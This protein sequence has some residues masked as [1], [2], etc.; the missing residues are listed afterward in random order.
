MHM[1]YPIC[2]Q[3]DVLINHSGHACLA[4]FGTSVLAISSSQSIDLSPG[5]EY[6]T[7]PIRWMSPEL[8]DP[9][10]FG[11]ENARPT[12]E[13]DCYALGMVIYEVLSGQRPYNEFVYPGVL[14]RV[15]GGKCPDRPQ[16][17]EGKLFTDAIWRLLKLCWKPQPSDR[18]SA[19]T[20]LLCLEGA[21]P[22]SGPPSDTN[23]GGETDLET[24]SDV[25]T[26]SSGTFSLLRPRFTTP[27][28][29]SPPNQVFCTL[30]PL[31]FECQAPV[32]LPSW[33]T[34]S[35]EQDHAWRERASDSIKW[36]SA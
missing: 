28:H 27:P 18:P 12:K 13:S 30:F 20:V 14:R 15:L 29:D 34:R 1:A 35:A 4:D 25:T 36:L 19:K 6:S 5:R 21:S 26:R 17:E 16:G 32:Y 24:L 11:F 8:I 22:P 23:G 10:S 7:L 2:P 3:I 33:C 31:H 9:E